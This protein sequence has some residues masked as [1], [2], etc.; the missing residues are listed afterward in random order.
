MTDQVTKVTISK[1]KYIELLSAQQ[2]MAALNSYGVD[3][4]EA[5][6]DA[7]WEAI[8]EFNEENST[9]FSSFEEIAQFLCE[10]ELSEKQL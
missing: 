1:E 4:W 3:S 7:K 5:Y 6:D 2:E 10:K 9:D 8:D